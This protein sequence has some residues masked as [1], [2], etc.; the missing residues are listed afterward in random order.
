MSLCDDS[1]YVL[2]GPTLIERLTLS[3]FKSH[4]NSNIEFN[5]GL[6]IFLGEVGA[7][8]TSVL[9]AISFA[10][11]GRY[12]ENVTKNEVI[13][14]GG[15]QTEITLVFSTTS[16]RYRINR[17]IHPKR[18]QIAK[19]WI[20]TGKEW[21]LV[22]EGSTAV[23]K[24]VEDLLGVDAST[25]LAALYASQGEIKEMLKTQPG[26]RRERLDRLLGIDMYERIWRTLGDANN[27]VLTELTKVQE[28]ASG[29]QLLQ[30]RLTELKTQRDE[31]KNE[32][33]M[34]QA[35]LSEIE[36]RMKPTVQQLIEYDDLKSQ[37]SQLE[38][39]IKSKKEE[40]ENV[41]TTLK[42]LQDKIAKAL[43]AEKTYLKYKKFLSLKE[44]L[45]S[46]KRRVE[47][48]LQEKRNLQTILKRDK[49]TQKE[50]EKRSIKL[51]SQLEKLRILKDSLVKYEAHKKALTKLEIEKKELEKTK[52]RVK[53][54]TIKAI[55][56][57]EA[58]KRKAQRV[59]DLGEC[60]TCLQIVA[61]EH[62][63]KIRRLTDESISEMKSRFTILENERMH[64]EERL[65]SLLQEVNLA[66]A[67]DRKFAETLA[68]IEV[69]ESRQSESD[70]TEKEVNE[71]NS[72]IK[73]TASIIESIDE[74]PTDLT[75]IDEKLLDITLKTNLAREAE[76]QMM[77]IEDF[78]TMQLEQ[79]KHLNEYQRQLMELK[80][81][82]DEVSDKY[83]TEKHLT[84]E[85]GVKTLHED[86]A[87]TQEA[88][89]RLEKAIANSNSR[90]QRD[91]KHL[92]EKERAWGK[93]K[94]L[95]VENS[96][97][98]ALRGSIREVVQPLKRRNSVLNVSSAFQS[99]YQELS[100]DNIDYATVDE[101]GNIDVIRN[102]EPSPV[103]S[104]S[105][106]ETTCAALALRLAI[107]SSLTKNQLL[108]LDEPTIHLDESYR[109][110]LRDFLSMHS[111]KQLIVVTHD[112]T[113][114]SL[115]AHIF[116]VE[117]KVGKS[118]V[119]P[120]VSKTGA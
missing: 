46:E 90:I 92:E 4:G 58:E 114:D 31:N 112:N 24:S 52:D 3:E 6:N 53:E 33:E 94:N 96:T 115:P 91:E 73:E 8:K 74:S 55:E 67:E 87:K 110:R 104:L 28:K 2:R 27:T 68:Q 108:L 76:K 43:K 22:V 56:L 51:K 62:K 37:L 54:E 38:T 109:A 61:E 79:E 47:I 106:G 80:S 36:E 100:N 25:F 113:F 50:A 88:I 32:L 34:L 81:L 111:F 23:S 17:T 99:F 42:S 29:F 103:N 102:G 7:G 93:V 59:S 45:E 119:S 95:K 63:E 70:A 57:V 85:A 44:D 101:D 65:S 39:R 21:R 75:K 30:K 26:K 16:G 72:R 20:L 98:D 5:P 18:T 69:L 40:I 117:K 66:T 118:I 60:P 86:L 11:F 14:R 116:T 71:L 41:S 97:L 120:I 12:A 77:A 49:I 89:V 84:I 19:L 82:N 48:N 15:D 10:L 1:K 13:R 78:K 83:D 105:G 64:T 107:C 9:E 35:F